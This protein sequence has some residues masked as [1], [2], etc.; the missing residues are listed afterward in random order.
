M[1]PLML[2][3]S[4][5]GLVSLAHANT[6]YYLMVPVKGK[7]EA[8]KKIGLNLSGY[9]LPSAV[10][11][12]PF[13]PFS[14]ADLLQVTGDPTFSGGGV[15]WSVAEGQL[16]EGLVLDAV[17][18]VLSGTPTNAANSTFTVKAT[19]KTREDSQFY[20]LLSVVVAVELLPATLPHATVA[21]PYS[22]NVRP[23]ANI[24]DASNPGIAPVFSA[25]QLPAN[26]QLSADG[27]LTGTPAPNS[28]TEGTQ[29]SVQVSYRGFAAS[30]TYTLSIKSA[31]MGD[32][33]SK[34][35]AC[36][37]GVAS[38]CATLQK[39]TNP[40]S[41]TSLSA[42]QRTLYL[43]QPFR[44]GGHGN[45]FVSTGKW[46]A[47]VKFSGALSDR[48]MGLLDSTFPVAQWPSTPNQA[49]SK[50]VVWMTAA[51]Q[52]HSG[53]AL[54]ASGVVVPS[55]GDTLGMAL[56]LPAGT[57]AFYHNCTK[58]ATVP[59]PA[60]W[61]SYTPGAVML[62]SSGTTSATLNAGQAEFA[63]PVPAGFN[64]GWW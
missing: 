10:V 3:L 42:D 54:V 43:T 37:V 45:R 11:G 51:R 7:E 40:D 48:W 53:S 31:A 35:G 15:R 30:R 12:K 58:V 52:I 59:L 38:G 29:V 2:L 4:A 14:F 41:S 61:T 17:T 64:K 46:Y 22:Y 18:G 33:V 25:I 13:A 44:R 39:S 9:P 23:L 62:N 26:F 6:D 56:D 55:I 60:G 20:E 32:G 5:L 1:K 63:C 57:V 49:G 21:Q 16:P 27:M 36:Q 19:Y 8:I 34:T 24:T 47:E 28:E 50:N